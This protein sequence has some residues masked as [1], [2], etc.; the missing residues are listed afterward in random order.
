MSR[1]VLLGKQTRCIL[2]GTMASPAGDE[3]YAA[4]PSY[5]TGAFVTASAGPEG[6]HG[7]ASVGV[8]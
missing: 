1:Y 8:Y 2:M 7:A 5:Q 3:F 6:G 4:G